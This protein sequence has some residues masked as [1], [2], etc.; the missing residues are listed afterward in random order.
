MQ[1]V[2]NKI[3]NNNMF[4]S[5]LLRLLNIMA[6]DNSSNQVFILKRLIKKKRFRKR[7]YMDTESNTKKIELVLAL[8]KKMIYL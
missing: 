6:V 1:F 2:I 7:L 3:T 4:K 8:K 5:S